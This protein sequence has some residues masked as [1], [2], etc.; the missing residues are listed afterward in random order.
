MAREVQMEKA[1]LTIHHIRNSLGTIHSKNEDIAKQ[2]E[3]YYR[4]LLVL[5]LQVSKQPLLQSFYI[6]MALPP[7]SKATAEQLE[8]TP[9]INFIRCLNK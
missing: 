7:I 9:W 3:V 5:R 1:S 4:K 2:F 8:E 6:T